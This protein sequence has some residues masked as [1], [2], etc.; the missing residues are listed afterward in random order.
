[1]PKWQGNAL[2]GATTARGD[3]IVFFPTGPVLQQA[4]ALVQPL[5]SS[6]STDAQSFTTNRVET[7]TT[8]R[9]F[10][11]LGRPATA[12]SPLLN[13]P[14]FVAARGAAQCTI[15]Q[16]PLDSSLTRDASLE[17]HHMLTKLKL[18]F[19]EMLYHVAASPHVDA[20]LAFVTGDGLLHTWAPESSVQTLGVDATMA[21]ERLLRCEYARCVGGSSDGL[22]SD[23]DGGSQRV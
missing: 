12:Q 7:G 23:H 9:Q 19:D 20:E 5:D 22:H 4:C 8:I 21:S 3:H 10:A 13:E 16:A 6:S 11:V 17:N 15:L 14:L 1:M 2:T 18:T